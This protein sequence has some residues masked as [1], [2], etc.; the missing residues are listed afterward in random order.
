MKEITLWWVDY[1][2]VPVAWCSQIVKCLTE[3]EKKCCSK[4]LV[5]AD[6]VSYR[7]VH[8]ALHELLAA[9][10]S[11]APGELE[12]V[13][14]P[15]QKPQL[16]GDRL[17]FNL[18]HTLDAALIAIS[19]DFAIG[20]DLEKVAPLEAVALARRFFALKEAEIIS[21]LSPEEQEKVY[22]QLWCG[23]EALTKMVGGKLYDY[24]RYDLHFWLE[25]DVIS[26]DLLEICG[27]LHN[28]VLADGY[29]GAISIAAL[30][31]ERYQIK[32]RS[33]T[34][35]YLRNFS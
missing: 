12:F 2:K 11:C 13:Y 26:I 4:L 14:G 30:P 32:L 27:H 20:V 29:V 23:K 17:N 19:P 9:E 35:E 8:G 31:G 6:R 18:S 22:L 16:S 5:E 34:D 25:Q 7:L 28:L 1:K 21:K 3:R 33:F 24:L 10:L 15:N